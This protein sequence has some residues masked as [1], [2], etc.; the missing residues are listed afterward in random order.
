MWCDIIIVQPAAK[1]WRA[2]SHEMPK[3]ELLKGL[4]NVPN[5]FP[6]FSTI[7]GPYNIDFWSFFFISRDGSVQVDY[8]ETPKR[9]TWFLVDVHKSTIF[10]ANDFFKTL[11]G[12]NVFVNIEMKNAGLVSRAQMARLLIESEYKFM[13]AKPE[14]YY[15]R[16]ADITEYI[17]LV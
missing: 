1:H 8:R 6:S 13:K 16:A 2:A 12:K 4:E 14:M 10:P 7:Y 17:N 3:V 15:S 9:C 5:D 11:K